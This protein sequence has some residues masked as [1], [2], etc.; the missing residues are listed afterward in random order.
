MSALRKAIKLSSNQALSLFFLLTLSLTCHASDMGTPCMWF[1]VLFVLGF[2]VSGVV[3]LLC[4]A[5]FIP[6]LR[7]KDVPDLKVAYVV[8]LVLIGIPLLFLIVVGLGQGFIIFG[9]AMGFFLATFLYS[10]VLKK[11]HKKTSG[12]SNDGSS[13]E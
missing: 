5:V 4:A 3:Y 6:Q 7:D 11:Y 1:S 13:G 2:I 8:P 10:N 9:L 12:E